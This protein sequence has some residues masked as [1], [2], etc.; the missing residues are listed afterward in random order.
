MNDKELKELAEYAAE[1]LGL[2]I[3]SKYIFYPEAFAELL[4]M[5]EL[6]NTFPKK[7]ADEIFFE[8]ELSSPILMHLAKRKLEGIIQPLNPGGKEWWWESHSG[9]VHVFRLKRFQQGNIAHFVGKHE[10]EYIAFW[11][12]VR[13][14]TR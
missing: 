2:E 5:G 6:D 11:I 7:K 3:H 10:N 8:D 4:L 9:S 13:E 12:A 14:A 1:F